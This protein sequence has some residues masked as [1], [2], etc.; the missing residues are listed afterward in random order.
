M[1]APVNHPA[2]KRV[3]PV[4]RA[5][6]VRTVDTTLLSSIHPHYSFPLL[7][8][9]SPHLPILIYIVFQVFNIL[10]PMTNAASASRCVIGVFD[11]SL[12]QLMARSLVAIGSIDHGECKPNPNPNPYSLF[13]VMVIPCMLFM[14]IFHV[15]NL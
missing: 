10:G 15:K 11:E 12:V 5:L 2:M 1:Y 8:P 3:G 14:S 13:R 4:R 6:G 7:L 9:L